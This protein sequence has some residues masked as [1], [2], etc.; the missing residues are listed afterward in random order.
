VKFLALV[1]S[2][3]LLGAASRHS[4]GIISELSI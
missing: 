1:I 4:I 3:T 2:L